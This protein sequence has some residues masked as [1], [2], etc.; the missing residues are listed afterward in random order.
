MNRQRPGAVLVTGASRGI[1]RAIALRLAEDGYD[2]VAHYGSSRQQA[3]TLT[4][5]A[6][7]PIRLVEADLADSQELP[8]LCAEVHELCTGGLAGI[9]PN[10]GIAVRKSFEETQPGDL[11]AM[12]AVNVT[13]PYVLT[14]GLR[15]LL[16]D[17]S[18][19]V[20]ISSIAAR[21]AFSD[22]SAYAMTKAA[23]EALT[24]HLAANLGPS[25]IR[26]NALGLGAI[27]TEMTPR[28][29]DA[30]GVDAVKAGQ[31]LK[32]VGR[33]EDAADAVSLLM[34]DQARWI[35]GAIIPVSGGT[36]L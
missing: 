36:R 13:A 14:Q 32:R 12:L 18:Q 34:S 11:A 9:V 5:I 1:G 4:E 17:G 21:A 6:A 10:A 27:N 7:R 30:S 23:I 2:V 35:T 19:I 22:L 29:R 3:Q 16:R 26:V 25:G 20:F 15:L 31:A 24:V 33:P 28:L 8:R